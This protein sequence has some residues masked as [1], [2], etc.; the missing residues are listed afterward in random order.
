MGRRAVQDKLLTIAARNLSPNGVAYVSYNTYPGWH[1]HETVRHMMR[2]HAGQ[3]AEPQEQVEQARALLKFLAS[4]SEGTGLYSQLLTVEADRLGR[5]PESYLFHEY[6]EQTNLPMYFREFI[7]R[8]ERVGLQYLSEAV[9]SEM[10]TS[11]F[12]ASVAATLE[13]IAQTFSISSNTW[14]SPAT[15]SFDRRFCATAPIIRNAR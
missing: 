3:F 7:E 9:V 11:H 8:A 15:G 2:Y 6:L 5:L 10:L 12:P 13:R 14:T 4:A 1:M